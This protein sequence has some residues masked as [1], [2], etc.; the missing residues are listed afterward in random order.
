VTPNYF[1]ESFS[2]FPSW[3]V[4]DPELALKLFA[5]TFTVLYLPKLLALVLALREPGI[6]AGSGG[7]LGLVRS[8]VAESIMSMLLSPV[9]MLIQSRV[10]ADVFMG[11]DSGWN[12]QNRDD[13]AMPLS[14]CASKHALHVAAGLALAVLAFHI[15]WAAFLW[16]LP[17][18]GA[19]LLSPLVSWASGIP[20]L[21]R[22]MWHWNLFRIPEE[23]TPAGTGPA[24]QDIAPEPLLEAAE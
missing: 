21:G 11:R 6:R 13:Q 8:V 10:V 7:A 16:L 5:I 9:M 2:L 1:P 17:I 14:E 19:L 18:A 24:M 15:S 23:A 12:A 4:F 20:E 22:R 3:P